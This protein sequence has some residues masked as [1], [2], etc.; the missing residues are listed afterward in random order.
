MFCP[1]GCPGTPASRS[2]PVERY[3]PDQRPLARL[4]DVLLYTCGHCGAGWYE[5]EQLAQARTEKLLPSA[6]VPTW[7]P[8]DI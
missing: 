8:G 5:P 1:N 3:A 4:P 6:T 7:D 2:L